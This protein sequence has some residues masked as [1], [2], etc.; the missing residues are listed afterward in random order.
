LIEALQ[1]LRGVAGIEFI[2]FSERDVVRHSLVKFIINAY[3]TFREKQG[4]SSR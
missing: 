1:A 4:P 2:E 3:K